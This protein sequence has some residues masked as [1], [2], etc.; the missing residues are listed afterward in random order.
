MIFD[1]NNTEFE[2]CNPAAK[3]VKHLKSNA[4]GMDKIILMLDCDPAGEN[5][6]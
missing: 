4:K 6:C 5:I 3:I 1:S 2:E